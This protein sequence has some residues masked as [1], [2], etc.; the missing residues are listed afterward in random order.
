MNNTLYGSDRNMG[1]AL[2]ETLL[3]LLESGIC[4]RV[5]GNVVHSLQRIIITALDD[6]FAAV[7]AFW[8]LF[9]SLFASTYANPP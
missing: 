4:E 7:D 8:S 1:C 6:Y 2:H 3:N 5:R 9:A